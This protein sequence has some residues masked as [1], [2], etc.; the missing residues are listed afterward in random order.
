M[1]PATRVALQPNYLI[2]LLGNYVT[3]SLQREFVIS[4]MGVLS[5]MLLHAGYTQAGGTGVALRVGVCTCPHPEFQLTYTSPQIW[6]VDEQS[7]PNPDGQH[8]AAITDLDGG[9][10]Q[11]FFHNISQHGGDEAWYNQKGVYD[12]FKELEP[13]SYEELFAA[14]KN[15]CALDERGFPFKVSQIDGIPQ[16][17]QVQGVTQARWHY[18]LGDEATGLLKELADASDNDAAEEQLFG[19][20]EKLQLIAGNHAMLMEEI[21]KDNQQL[22]G[23]I[24]AEMAILARDFKENKIQLP[25]DYLEPEYEKEGDVEEGGGGG[26]GGEGGNASSA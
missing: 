23:R 12:H 25:L 22:F 14:Y 26:G 9:V 11:P 20:Y 19:A 8:D 1:P 21:G 4:R 24:S 10:W 5:N 6:L 16:V 18:A 15:L 7:S 13:T 3:R 17:H 2:R